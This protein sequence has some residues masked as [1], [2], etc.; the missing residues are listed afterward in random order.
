MDSGQFC[1]GNWGPSCWLWQGE[2]RVCSSE[3][4]RRSEKQLFE[5]LRCCLCARWLCAIA[6]YLGVEGDLVPSG[7]KISSLS[8][9]IMC[10]VIRTG[11]SS[12]ERY[13]FNKVTAR[14]LLYPQTHLTVRVNSRIACQGASSRRRCG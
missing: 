6:L 1:A 4:E 12:D 2:L 7:G 13:P 14:H 10:A 3:F 9:E 11:S 8:P 5:K